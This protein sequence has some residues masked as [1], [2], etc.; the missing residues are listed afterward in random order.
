M[1]RSDAYRHCHSIVLAAGAATRFGGGKLLARFRDRP[2]VAWACRA[3]LHSP[4]ESVTV[5]LG[6]RA[7]EVERALAAL[8]DARLRTIRC[9]NWQDGLAASLRCGLACLPLECRAVLIFL[10]DMPNVDAGMTARLLDAVLNGA[11]AAL[12]EFAGL[13]GHPVAL[14]SVFF[15]RIESLEGDCGARA[16]LKDDPGVMW[17]PVDN[18]GCI[19]DIDTRE[20]IDGLA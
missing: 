19:Q 16:F 10:G 8:T 13:P 9:R 7:D 5:V 6:S 15:D 3:A 18:P 17:I 11:T 20:D 12:P 4:V 2:L 1:S 14:G